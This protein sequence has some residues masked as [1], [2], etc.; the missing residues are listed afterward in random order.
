MTDGYV[1]YHREVGIHM[2]VVRLGSNVFCFR[3]HL[4]RFLYHEKNAP[5]HL[6]LDS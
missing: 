2:G 6:P 3:V 5:E 1:G 4:L